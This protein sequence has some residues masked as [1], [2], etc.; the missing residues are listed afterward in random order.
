MA[1]TQVADVIVPDI[2]EQYVIERTAELPA[3]AQAGIVNAAPEF[4][5]LASGGGNVANMPFWQD[6]SGARQVLSDS[7]TLTTNK[8]AASADIA[9]IHNDGNAWS[10]NLLASL[11]SGDDPM[12]AIGDL[13]AEY[14]AREDED[15][16][17]SC[18][19]G[20]FLSLDAEAGDPNILKLA[21]ESK[22]GTTDANRLTGTTFVDAL[23]VLGDRNARLTAVA[24]HSA[25]EAYL[26][27]QDL[28]D[29]LPDSEGKATIAVFQGRRVVVDDDLPTRVGTTDGTVYTTVL[30]GDGAF[31]KGAASLSGEPLDGGF[32]TEGVEFARV[33]L[34]SDSILIN[35]RRHILHPR[36]IK[37]TSSSVAGE[38]P[39]NTELEAAA[40]W[41]IVF[42]SKNVR[43]V[44][45]EHNNANA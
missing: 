8:I 12:A 6:I 42:E 3:F 4:D 31:A 29:Y 7:G 33:A 28:I 5:A 18:I 41:D 20:L 43:L 37:F 40:N 15:M 36:G 44:I 24:M 25:T 45:V 16:L 1:K 34:D 13:V 21:S 14:W 19:K 35:R 27:K 17:V 10:T 38:S 32:G 26:K 11:L 22:A 9:A 30:F 2:F 23:Q 39:T